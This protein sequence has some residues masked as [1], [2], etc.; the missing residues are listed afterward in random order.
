MTSERPLRARN[1]SVCQSTQLP[2]TKTRRIAE[3][4][5][6]ADWADPDLSTPRRKSTGRACT[7]ARIAA[8]V[9]RMDPS[10]GADTSSA[11]T[12]GGGRPAHL[13]VV[14]L[15]PENRD[16]C[17]VGV[18]LRDGRERQAQYLYGNSSMS[19]ECC[20]VAF[21]EVSEFEMLVCLGTS[22]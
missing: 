10:S 20:E 15:T 12:R 16:E 8:R 19:A 18:V 3:V 4:V 17:H 2:G 1:F 9:E 7:S 6:G 5:W 22:V 13:K 11:R 14:N 21:Q